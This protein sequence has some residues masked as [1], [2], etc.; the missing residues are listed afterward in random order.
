MEA[1]FGLTVGGCI[2]PDDDAPFFAIGTR[3]IVIDHL[4]ATGEVFHLA[5]YQPAL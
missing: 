5:V 2:F 4:D 3:Q 1:V